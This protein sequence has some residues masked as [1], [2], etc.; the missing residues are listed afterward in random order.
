[1]FLEES[2]PERNL[3]SA[4]Y[5]KRFVD[6]T[7]TNKLHRHP[8]CEIMIIEKG[9]VAVTALGNTVNLGA[10][11]VIFY[12]PGLIYKYFTSS[13]EMYARYRIR[14]YPEILSNISEDISD[15][16]SKYTAKNLN[17]GDFEDVLS[18]AKLIYKRSSERAEEQPTELLKNLLISLLSLLFGAPA[19]GTKEPDSYVHKVTVYIKK[20]CHGKLTA[21]DV[22]EHFFVS[23]GKLNYDLKSYCD[24]SV[25]EYITLARV[26]LA[27]ELLSKGYSVSLTAENS[28]FSTPSYFIKV[29]TAYTG[30]T[31][32]KFRTEN[33][34]K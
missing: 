18:L 33:V 20:M 6:P 22:A 1:M 5:L 13:K 34:K 19:A 29:F 25:S 4:D 8:C 26:E 11:S 32:L 30:M 2:Y 31:P 24:M 9:E 3:V 14:F 12:P 10:E 15:R 17:H 28:G 21:S 27:K 7:S 23:R 16:L